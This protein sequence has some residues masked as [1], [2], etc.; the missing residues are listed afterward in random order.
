M[1]HKRFSKTQLATS[2]SL[3]LGASAISPVFAADEKEI[4][5]NIEVIEVT[6]I[7]ASMIKAMD[8]KRDAHGVVD[9]IS[10]EDMG[11]FPDTN[12]AESL[13][14]ISGV[15]IDRSN[16]EG[17]HVTV[18]GFGPN[19]NLVTLNGRQM[20]T[21]AMGMTSAPSTRSFDFGNLAS[22]S[23][24]AVEIYK[25]GRAANPSGGIGSTINI[26]TARPLN[27]PGLKASLGVKGVMDTTVETGN[28]ITPE[29]SG[30]FSNTFAD[31]TFGI[32]VT[33]SYQ[34][35]DSREQ[36]AEVSGWRANSLGDLSSATVNNSNLNPDDNTWLPR[37]FKYDVGDIERTRTNAQVV[38]QYKPVQNITATL[39]Y[40]YAENETSSDRNHFGVWFNGGGNVNEVT[41]NEHG[42][43]LFLDETGGTMDYFGYDN[44]AGSENNSIGFNIEW[45][46]NDTLSFTF[47]YHNS[48][49]ESKGLD[50]GNNSFII[51]G[52]KIDGK[53]VD[54]TN[55]EIPFLELDFMD[56]TTGITPDQ[57]APN[58]AIANSSAMK[59]DI[60]QFRLD[61]NWVN[62]G[63]SALSSIDFGVSFVE[64][65]SFSQ[66]SSGFY[67]V[68]TQAS[69]A[70]FDNDIFVKKGTDGLFTS[71][72]GSVLPYFYSFDG[73]IAL[74]Q[75]EA[76]LGIDFNPGAP[77]DD[78]TVIEETTSAYIQF[79][80]ESEFN[81]MPISTVAGF[82]YEQSDVS[83][84]SLEKELLYVEWFSSTEFESISANESTYTDVGSDYDLF[85]PSL[86][87]NIELTDD[88][89]A[90]FSYSRT[91]TRN[92]LSA[93]R[94][95]TSMNDKPKIGARTGYR[96]NPSLL[97]YTAD[98]IDLSL[99]YYYDEGSYVSAGYFS[100]NVDNFLVTTVEQ[101]TLDGIYDPYNGA[102]SDLARQ[103]LIDEGIQLTEENIFDR[104]LENQGGDAITIIGDATDE[105]VVWGINKP[106]NGETVSIDGWEFAVQHLF[107]ESGFGTIAN[108]T[109]VSGDVGYNNEQIGVQFAL[110]G[111]SDS[112]NLVA[113][114][115][116]DGI[117][118]RIAYNWRDEFLSAI[119]QQ[120]GGANE[121]QH[122]EAYGQWDVSA[123]FEISENFTVFVEGLN[124]TEETQRIY[125]RYEEQLLNARQY[126]AR[127]NL[128][129]RYNF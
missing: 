121:P 86:D 77:K 24:S 17:S 26:I 104:M 98:N 72:T 64:M 125:G 93:M 5:E 71:F 50:D 51:V 38:L 41:I 65:S 89:L 20:P 55:R 31:D 21:A 35:R 115:D 28:D 16:N 90:R 34:K 60:E 33:G 47:D 12:L 66:F 56:I 74:Q 6:G 9:A 57:I 97:P 113:F 1:K 99:E 91:V 58:I 13:Q 109:I 81:G 43:T 75:A 120:E 105:L 48:T 102:R 78:H 127:Y 18:R 101:E 117:Q 83:A 79:T 62:D 14:R 27:N 40:T 111:L 44:S 94:G 68:A 87:I 39:D 36:N 84:S 54:F 37:N 11:K 96:G 7:R 10:A 3:I 88:L 2:L 70:Y 61:G 52:T 103:Q 15:S 29:L 128:G 95:T 53:S 45:L 49:A 126:G 106:T 67:G 110:P 63:N 19:F 32:L 82:R 108:F 69:S 85:L 124:I 92:N 73:A 46:A 42:T 30:L 129:M 119:G 112:A 114:Y 59:T 122:T 107:G 76:G 22:E 8:I 23:V 100:K 116:K 118:A 4:D 25:T 80:F 123:S